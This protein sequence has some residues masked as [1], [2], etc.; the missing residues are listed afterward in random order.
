M[1]FAWKKSELS[2]LAKIGRYPSFC[3]NVTE[4]KKISIYAI[5]EM[6]EQDRKLDV[7]DVTLFFTLYGNGNGNGNIT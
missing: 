1:N 7:M 6:I 5:V 4:N 2:L 3:F